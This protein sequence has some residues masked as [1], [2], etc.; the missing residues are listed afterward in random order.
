MARNRVSLL[1]T[2]PLVFE[3]LIYDLFVLLCHLNLSPYC[4]YA[5]KQVKIGLVLFKTILKVIIFV[6]NSLS[7][8][9]TKQQNKDGCVIF[10]IYHYLVRTTKQRG[11]RVILVAMKL[12]RIISKTFCIKFTSLDNK[13]KR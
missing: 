12:I 6:K 5:K 9:Q 11:L 10:F 2:C 3:C 13:I 7:L 8:H 4:H 1:H